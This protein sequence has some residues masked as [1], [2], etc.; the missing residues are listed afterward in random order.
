MPTT[1]LKGAHLSLQQDRLW[2]FQQ[3]S[4][5]YRS[6]CTVFMKGTL[7]YQMFQQALQQL[8]EQHGIFQTVFYCPAGMDVPI[9]VMGHPIEFSCPIISLEAIAE[10]R[11]H[12]L[13]HVLLM[14][15]QEQAFD[16]EHGPLFRP[17]V[18]RL[19]AET[20][21]LFISLPALC[22]DAFTLPLLMA[23]LVK[24]YIARLSGQELTEEPLQYTAVSAWQKQLLLE[25]G[26]GAKMARE[27]WK[28]CDVSQ[29]AQVQ[30]LLEQ[31]GIVNHRSPQATQK[32]IF[33]PL[34]YPLTVEEAISMRIHALASHYEVSVT[35]ILL[36]CW[37]IV[38]WRLTDEPQLVIGVA[39]NGRCYEELAE[40]LGLYTCFVPFRAYLKDDWTFEQVVAFIEPLL[41]AT[42]KY[43]SYFSWPSV[44][45][46]KTDS[47]GPS[48]FPVAFEHERWPASFPAEKVSFS[49]DQRFCCTEPFRLKLSIL[50]VGERLQLELHY[51]PQSVIAKRV[52]RLASMLQ[53]LLQSV[54]EQP[55]ALVGA[56]TVI[57]ADEQSYLLTTLRA[58]V[59]LL[60]AQG[61]HRLFE[62][63]V[64]RAPSQLAVISTR[65]QL[66]YQQLNERANRLAQVL[67]KRGVGSNVLVGLCMARSAQMLVGLLAILKA[68]GA[69]MPLDAG[70]PPARLMYQLE[71]S[72]AVFLLAQQEVSICLPEWGGRML[73]LEDLE[74]EMS[75]APAGDLP[76]GS[77]AEDLAYVIYTSG[78][79]GMPKGVM[80]QQSSVVNYTQA[81]CELL[82]AEPR[83]QYATVSTLA[84]DLGNTA[85]F[86]ALASGGCVQVLD[87]EMVTSTEAMMRWV[88]HHPIDVL[89]IVP[90]HLSALLAGE[91]GKGVLPRRALVLGG[92]VLPPSLLERIRQLGS[93]CEVY[94]HY[95]PTEATIGVLVNPL[96]RMGGVKEETG[97]TIPLGRPITNTQVYVLDRRMQVIP[98]G[99]TGELYIGGAGLAIG[100][101]GQG[102]QTAERFV[103]H[104][105]SLQAGARLYR[106]G[107]LAR[108]SEEGKIEF[109]GRC[110]NQVKLRGY[111]IE[112]AEVEIALRQH[113]NIRDSAVVVQEDSSAGPY[114]VGYI[115][116][117]K[118]PIPAGMNIG[119]FLRER[120]PGYMVPSSF[121][122]LKFLPLSAN[123]KVDQQQLAVA[124]REENTS[125]SSLVDVGSQ[126]RTIVQPRDAIEWQLLQ[127]WE[128]VL[129]MQPLSIIDDFFNLGGH[130]LLAV[131][132]MSH[133]AKHFGQH[134]D[135]A[136]LFEHPTVAEFAVVLRQQVTSEE[137]SPVVAIQSQGSRPPFFCVPPGGGTA[138][139]YANL[140]RRLGPDQPFYGLHTPDPGSVEERLGTV[141]AIALHY[142][143]A[144]QAVQPQG[145]YLLGGWSSGGV[146]AFEMAQQLQKQGKQVDLLAILDSWMPDAQ[147]RA[148]TREEEINLGDP[149]VIKWLIRHF[150]I[151]VPDDFD[152][153]EL[154]EQLNYATDHAKKIHAIPVDTSLELVRRYTRIILLNR[155]IVHLYDPQSYAYSIDYF[156]SSASIDLTG[157]LGEREGS[158]EI[159]VRLDRLEVWRELAQGGLYVHLVPG[160]HSSMVEE[161]HVQVLA[162]ALKQCIDRVCERLAERAGGYMNGSKTHR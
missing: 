149:G 98:M 17:V 141:K 33:E 79:T 24:R 4:R 101:I 102:E 70:N 57:T 150:K 105:W 85:I 130:S 22:A 16:L 48:F 139:C 9:Q 99:V 69:Y 45:N 112:V 106:T 136:T 122:Y 81:L 72:R 120:L 14:S 36:A 13:L 153:R 119:E 89:K 26:E 52:P 131:R 152:Q 135:L 51:D 113:P 148:K 127:I 134:L 97:A 147:L 30:Q 138:F 96:S 38:L 21:L 159:P 74:Q 73:W 154:D 34:I 7:N 121:V 104:P 146:I 83:W 54:V 90:S 109:V 137:R 125:L 6:Q 110:D 161:P 1:A 80:I 41:E 126:S 93:R 61:L 27:F 68:G 50:Q 128:D 77:E 140:A 95:G 44:S 20:T 23:D 42:T 43:Q 47:V 160:D 117:R 142:L 75:Q 29:V 62:A 91:S 84:A 151:A 10:P 132:L 86:C 158:A 76:G 107:D 8:V 103:P 66:T 40:V 115:V 108:S 60:P 15:S 156:A 82:K 157:S 67:R 155:H 19:S 35:A 31:A 3:G 114:L 25:E 88:E 12:S 32:A 71:E 2:S 64:R 145:P 78:S 92:E 116:P 123:G 58:P 162:H 5:T 129:Q 144:L 37:L 63:H 118:L 28:K 18:F 143:A 11:Q 124:K 100:Y 59:R 49:L 111:R 56:L 55:Q 46:A 65:E 87:Y 53:V 133:I 39:C 94:N